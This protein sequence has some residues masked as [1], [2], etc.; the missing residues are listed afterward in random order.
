MLTLI[1]FSWIS[2]AFSVRFDNLR[3]SSLASQKERFSPECSFSTNSLNA[4][5]HWLFFI[6]S[7]RE[8]R[9]LVRSLGESRSSS[10]CNSRREDSDFSVSSTRRARRSRAFLISLAETQVAAKFTFSGRD[11]R[12]EGFSESHESLKGDARLVEDAFLEKKFEVDSVLDMLDGIVFRFPFD[13]RSMVEELVCEL[14]AFRERNSPDSYSDSSSVCG[15][16]LWLSKWSARWWK[17]LVE[18]E[19]FRRRFRIVSRAPDINL[20][21]AMSIRAGPNDFRRFLVAPSLKEINC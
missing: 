6:T 16:R 4:R 14:D 3:Y 11:L 19:L 12:S 9:Q 5:R 2:S 18:T 1:N 21:K 7:L 10:D 15:I 8:T 20:T 13:D 17:P